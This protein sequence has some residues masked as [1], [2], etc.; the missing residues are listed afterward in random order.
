MSKSQPVETK[1]IAGAGGAGA[2]A[3]TSTFL[4]WLLGV[5]LWGAPNDADHA[6]DAVL[7][8]PAPVSVL[9][10][11]VITS[12]FAYVAGYAAK[13]T[14]RG[15]QGSILDGTLVR[16]LLVIVLALAALWLFAQLFD[17]RG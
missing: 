12:A 3:A 9:L 1:V 16:V 2:G 6:T 14:P 17:Y 5:T 15:D 7:A 8:V 10:A 4:V 11:L 13:H